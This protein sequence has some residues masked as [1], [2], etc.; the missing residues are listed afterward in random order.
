MGRLRSCD[1]EAPVPPAVYGESDGDW[2]KLGS[3]ILYVFFDVDG[4]LSLSDHLH[5]LAFQ[6]LCKRENCDHAINEAFFNKHISGRHNDDIVEVLFPSWP[7]D[8]KT[9]FAEE[10]EELFRT[11]CRNGGADRLPGVSP[12]NSGVYLH[13]LSRI[14]HD[15]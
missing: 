7:K 14:Q 1:G 12:G 8:K 5:L 2:P 15:L 3:D 6:K 10:K 11:M 4:T 13:S 9:A